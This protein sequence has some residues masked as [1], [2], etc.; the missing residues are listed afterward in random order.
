M[1]LTINIPNTQI[2][3]LGKSEEEMLLPLAIFMYSEWKM[4]SG[5][6]ARMAGLSRI[7]FLDELAKRCV[8]VNYDVQELE[9]DVKNWENFKLKHDSHQRYDL[10]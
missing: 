7:A 8:P 2:Q 1:E 10:P 3:H 4:S 6:C 5:R 9:Q